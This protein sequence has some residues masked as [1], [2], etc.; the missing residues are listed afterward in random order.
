MGHMA[1]RVTSVVI[2]LFSLWVCKESLMLLQDSFVMGNP[3]YRS[4]GLMPLIIAAALFFCGGWLVIGTVIRRNKKQM[5]RTCPSLHFLPP[6]G[7]FAWIVIYC[8]ILLP[9]LHY[10]VA[11]TIFLFPLM[12]L[13]SKKLFISLLSSISISLALT[14]IFSRGAQ[15]PLP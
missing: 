13:F 10:G 14:L 5:E 9:I 11:T 6:I 7:V 8:I 15:I 4:A 12:V 3:W 1:D 2:M